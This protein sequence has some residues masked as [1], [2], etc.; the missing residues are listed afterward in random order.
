VR[1]ALKVKAEAYIFLKIL[2]NAS[3]GK[4]GFRKSSAR[5][6]T[7]VNTEKRHRDNDDRPDLETAVF[8]KTG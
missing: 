7:K 4:I 2:L 3:Q 6:N 8:H 5:A 1:S